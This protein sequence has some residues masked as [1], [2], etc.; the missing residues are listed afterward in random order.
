MRAAP[1]ILLASVTYAA[2]GSRAPAL[3]G[4]TPVHGGSV[5][6][7]LAGDGSAR[8]PSVRSDVGLFVAAAAASG[9]VARDDAGRVVR[10]VSVELTPYVGER[11]PGS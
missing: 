6:I 2:C 11:V 7:R 1:L 10:L 5:R 8:P 3:V 9:L 4:P